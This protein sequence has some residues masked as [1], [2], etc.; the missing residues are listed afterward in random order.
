MNMN[1]LIA[2][3]TSQEIMFV[4][5]ISAIACIISFVVYFIRKKS[6]LL[7]RRHNTKELN[8]LVEEVR[9]RVP[10]EDTPVAYSS[11]VIQSVEEMHPT[12]EVL[13]LDGND[14]FEYTSIEPDQE[15]ARLELQRL[16]DELKAQEEKE[17]AEELARLEQ[18]RLE[19]ERQAKLESEKEEVINIDEYED[20]QEATAIISLDELLEKSRDLYS[21]NELNQYASDNSQPI[22]IQDLE[23]QM[24]R[25]VTKYEEPFVIENVVVDDEV[26]E[27]VNEE[28]VIIETHEVVEPVH[29]KFKATPIISPIF[30]IERTPSEDN[31]LALENT[32]NYEKLD[33]QIKKQNEFSMTLKEFQKN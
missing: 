1:D 22:S 30:G 28:P 25:S 18:E 4:Y 9:E 16:K 27:V 17:R 26:V 31:S 2:F 7:R 33:A 3:L 20:N 12:I 29:S 11:P 14:E 32:A 15:T 19:A 23:K 5:L 6:E 21:I 24:S 10:V 13:D 8:K